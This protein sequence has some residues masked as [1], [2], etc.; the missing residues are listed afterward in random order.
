MGKTNEQLTKLLVNLAV[1]A[2]HGA[3][4]FSGRRLRILDPLCGRGTTLNQVIRY[5]FDAAGVEINGRDIDAW[6]SFFTT[7]LK[8]KR[9]KH[10][11]DRRRIRHDGRVS[12][13]RIEVRIGREGGG[14]IQHASVVTGTTTELV[15]Y[16]G[17]A[18]VDGI[19]TDLPYGVQHGSVVGEHR[20]R[21]PDDLLSEAL[22]AWREVLRPGGAVAMAC[23][24]KTLS[25]PTPS[26][27]SPPPASRSSSATAA[28]STGSTGPSPVT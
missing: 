11:V 28:S 26:R 9:V 5:G 3:D 23:N 27:R 14:D 7:W 4:G 15:A 24:T 6:V 22:P 12:G 17:A 18:S 1:A 21:R 8:D 19:V 10:H 2:G 16:F 13:H 25:R 20:I